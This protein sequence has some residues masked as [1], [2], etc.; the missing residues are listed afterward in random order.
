MTFIETLQEIKK[1][2]STL[3][4]GTDYLEKALSPLSNKRNGRLAVNV[5]DLNDL[6][7]LFK[8]L[9]NQL[10]ELHEQVQDFEENILANLVNGSNL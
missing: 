3:A 8:I 10:T 4:T 7:I 5:A 1:I 6:W 9:E 2:H